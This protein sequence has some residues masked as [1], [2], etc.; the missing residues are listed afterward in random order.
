MRHVVPAARLA[1][2]ALFA[3]TGV[4]GFLGLLPL[5]A[6]HAFQ[7]MLIESGWMKV[8]KAI[9]LGAGLLLLSN[10]FVPLGLALLAPG[11][12]SI[13]LYHLLLDP[14]FL[15]I[16]PVIVAL[17]GFLLWTYRGSFRGLLVRDAQP[18]A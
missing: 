17:E 10:R 14:A 3:A 16:V 4:G 11:V 5:A 1:L 12:V 2:G 7:V 15:W 18:G 8:V 6:P 9:E 13:T